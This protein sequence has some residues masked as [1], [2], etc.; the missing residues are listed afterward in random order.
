MM[1]SLVI[2]IDKQRI[3]YIIQNTVLN[4]I[5]V[6]KVKEASWLVKKVLCSIIL[7]IIIILTFYKSFSVNFI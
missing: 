3:L 2:I 1:L 4:G 6:A 5:M 7:F